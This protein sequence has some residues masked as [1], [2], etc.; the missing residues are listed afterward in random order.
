M[1]KTIISILFAIAL[2][3]PLQLFQAQI[4]ISHTERY[5]EVKLNKEKYLPC[6]PMFAE[7]KAKLPVTDEE[8]LFLHETTISVSFED[9][10]KKV[11]G[12]GVNFET[13][14][15]LPKVV[16]PLVILNK[17]ANEDEI[18][19]Y[20]RKVS[21]DAVNGLF[22]KAGKY[23]IQF[24]LYSLN[25]PNNEITSNL[26]EI[27]IEEPTGI[28][29]EAFEFISKYNGVTTFNWVWEEKNGIALLEEFVAKYAQSIY[30]EKAILYLG[31]IYK[32]KDQLEKA[33]IEFEK[34]K[35]SEN[36]LVA[37]EASKALQDITARKACLLKQKQPE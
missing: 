12:L 27:T 26:I 33:Q 32:A 35:S 28:N 15:R 30:G 18:T 6:E 1:K 16:D 14:Q 3:I 20:Q 7:F 31:N 9:Q 13:P 5:F 25:A 8:P 36:K 4:S 34:I 22:R 2:L 11:V 37:D 21:I 29:K 17:S 24:I 23:Q 10:A 19:T